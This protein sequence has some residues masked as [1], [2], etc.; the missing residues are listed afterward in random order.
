[1]ARRQAEIAPPSGMQTPALSTTV[2]AVN[3]GTSARDDYRRK[4]QQRQ[5]VLF[6]TIS[7]VLALLM[8]LAMLVW[9]GIL[10]FP[11]KEK[12]SEAPD[13]NKVITPCISSDAKA[14]ELNTITVKVFNST[15]RTGLAG[16]VGQELTARG[17]S[18]AQTENWK[19]GSKFTASARIATGPRGINAAYTIAQYFPKSVIQYDSSMSDEIISIVVGDGYQD[20]LTADQVKKDNPEGKLKSAPGCVNVSKAGAN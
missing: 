13:P 9:T 2:E 8:V 3:E 6:G 15:N 1:M 7:A 14:T 16:A 12:F 5:T 17:V 11:F 18:V 19:G 10:P 4:I 20:V